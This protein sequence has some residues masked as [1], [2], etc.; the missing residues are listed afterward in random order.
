DMFTITVR[1][2]RTPA[3]LDMV[4]ANT[5]PTVRA[6]YRLS[7]AGDPKPGKLWIAFPKDGSGPRPSGFDGGPKTVE[8]YELARVAD[9][10]PAPQPG[11]SD[12]IDA[13]IQ[14]RLEQQ[15]AVADAAAAK[16]E[17]HRKELEDAKKR[18]AAAEAKLAAALEQLQ[19]ERDL[20]RAAEREARAQ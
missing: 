18:A 17:R 8:V 12:L 9:D 3:E 10:K 14:A 11:A 5:G 4:R 6:I 7:P 16:A 19:A 20:A 2:D 1:S 13:Q 15:R